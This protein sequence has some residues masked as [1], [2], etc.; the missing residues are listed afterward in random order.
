MSV[1]VFED[2]NE[3]V[4][5]YGVRV[6]GRDRQAR[7]VSPDAAR[8]LGELIEA[9]HERRLSDEDPPTIPFDR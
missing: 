8:R 1:E 6:N 3:P 2:P 4:Y 7:W 9:E 5:R